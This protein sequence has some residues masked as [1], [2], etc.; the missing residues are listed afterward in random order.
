MDLATTLTHY[1]ARIDRVLE[2]CLENLTFQSIPL[3]K[4]MHHGVL[5]GGKECVLFWSTRLER[6]LVSTLKC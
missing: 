3:Y 2:E 1:R 5:L 4:A 6:C